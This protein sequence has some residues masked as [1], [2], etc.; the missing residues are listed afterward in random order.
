MN[1]LFTE[2][3]KYINNNLSHISWEL[4]GR[5]LFSN[6]YMNLP[7]TSYYT[8]KIKIVSVIIFYIKYKT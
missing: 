2:S 4:K 6:N 8:L 1:S 7:Y 5:L 3:K